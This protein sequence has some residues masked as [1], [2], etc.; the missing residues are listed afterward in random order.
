MPRRHC[1]SNATP[2][3]ATSSARANCS[4]AT[5]P[6]A[7]SRSLHPAPASTSATKGG[8]WARTSYPPAAAIFAASYPK[9]DVFCDR[10]LAVDRPSKL[11]AGLTRG[12]QGRRR[13]LLHTMH[14]GVDWCA[15]AVWDD[16][17]L[18]RSLS[19][20]ADDGILENLGQPLAFEAPFWAGDRRVETAPGAPRVSSRLPSRRARRGGSPSRSSA[21][22]SRAASWRSIH[23]AFR[24]R[25]SGS[26]N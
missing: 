8:P 20:S 19:I 14:S 21:S 9:L 18:L 11:P 24:W 15:F 16:G 26:V 17:K 10:E 6:G 3:R 23:G 7:W 5:E 12:T 2:I 4:I 22:S 1:S 13:V 25:A